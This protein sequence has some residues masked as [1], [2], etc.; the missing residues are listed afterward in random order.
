M[1]SKECEI[2]HVEP[3]SLRDKE[4]IF[5]FDKNPRMQCD[6]YRSLTNT[7]TEDEINSPLELTIDKNVID[8]YPIKNISELS[9][10]FKVLTRKNE[11]ENIVPEKCIE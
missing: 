6:S 8:Q 11:D 5:K 3:S 10:C 2:P 4:N 9:C 7:Q 1:K